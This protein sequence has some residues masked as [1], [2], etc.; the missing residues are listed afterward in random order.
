[1]Y[2]QDGKRDY[3]QTTL[4]TAGAA[5]FVMVALVVLFGAV[6]GAC[7]GDLCGDGRAGSDHL[8]LFLHC[9]LLLLWGVGEDGGA[10][11][12]ADVGPLSILGGGIVHVPEDLEQ[13]LVGNDLGIKGDFDG[14][15]M[16]GIAIADGAIGGI[17]C[18]AASIADLSFE[19]ACDFSKFGLDAPK[20]S[21]GKGGF[22]SSH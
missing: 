3:C 11:L 16:A 19:N 8:L 12:G 4:E 9:D 10:V 17:F 15:G 18:V 21:S 14:F 13:I 20:T 2:L 7:R 22:F 6:E 5:V 1:M